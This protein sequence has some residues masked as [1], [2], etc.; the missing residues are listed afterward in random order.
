MKDMCLYVLSNVFDEYYVRLDFGGHP[1][2][3]DK[4]QHA[5]LYKTLS[6]AENIARHFKGVTITKYSLTPVQL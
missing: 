3:S 4:P 5:K 6:S 1:R 2:W